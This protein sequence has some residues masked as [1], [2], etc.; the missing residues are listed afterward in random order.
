MTKKIK[1]NQKK[2]QNNCDNY[3]TMQVYGCAF[4]SVPVLLV[5]LRMLVCVPAVI[6]VLAV[7]R[8]YKPKT[9]NCFGKNH[10]GKQIFDFKKKVCERTG[11]TSSP[12]REVK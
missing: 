12:G 3:N 2:I 4:C 9:A 10:F 1:N 7:W 11:F 8:R 5:Y 6:E